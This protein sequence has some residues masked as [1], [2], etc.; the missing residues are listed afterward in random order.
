[1]KFKL[2]ELDLSSHGYLF[3]GKEQRKAT[4]TDVIYISENRL[5][6]SSLLG[7]K[8]YLVNVDG[9]D[10]NIIDEISTDGYIDLMDYKDE[11]IVASNASGD[12]LEGSVSIFKIINDKITPIKTIYTSKKVRFH[13]C[14]IIDDKNVIIGSNDERTPGLYFLNIETEEFYNTIKFDLRV[15]DLC[16]NDDKLLVVASKTSPG[17]GKVNVT[18]SILYLYD[19]KSMKLLNKLVFKGQC[20]AL[21]MV[22]NDGFIAL[23]CEH[24][25]VHFKLQ[26]SNLEYIKLIGGFNFPHGVETKFGK[27]LVTNY[28]DNSIDILPL[29]DLI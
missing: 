10:L 25:L 13:G 19:F 2:P 4:A 5:I 7:K 14:L 27:V 1:M 18:D 20:D 24:S 11:M 12:G 15:K 21:C 6:A 23:Q 9:E 29:S 26:D 8:L 17:G 16:F 28:G 22:G 3:C